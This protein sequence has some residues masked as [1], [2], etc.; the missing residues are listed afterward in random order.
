M[1]GIEKF[2]RILGR[3]VALRSDREEFLREFDLDYAGFSTA[4]LKGRKPDLDFAFREKLGGEID[5]YLN[6]LFREEISHAD[7]P[8]FYPLVLREIFRSN[9]DFLFFHGGV[10]ARE[11]SALMISGPPG[12]GKTTLTMKAVRSGFSFFSDEFCPVEFETNLIHPFPRA[13]RVASGT[14]RHGKKTIRPV[15]SLGRPVG[16]KPVKP[17]CLVLLDPVFETE[18]RAELILRV[19]KEWIDEVAGRLPESPLRIERFPGSAYGEVILPYE[20]DIETQNRLVRKVLGLR[21]L[22]LETAL[23]ELPAIDFSAPPRLEKI[24][25]AKA[26]PLWMGHLYDRSHPILT[27]KPGAALFHTAGILRNTA[28]FRL[29]PGDLTETGKLLLA[30]WKQAAVK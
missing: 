24:S 23:S 30:A 1:P 26:A 22:I 10:S 4:P 21:D 29:V 18:P 20:G 15:E 27:E 11:S 25:P 9:P 6:G 7:I 12:S 19:R 28:C 3:E 17:R 2:Y 14:D 16:R 13:V 5:V 8:F